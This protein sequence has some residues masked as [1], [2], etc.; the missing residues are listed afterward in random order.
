MRLCCKLLFIMTW[1]DSLLFV[2]RKKKNTFIDLFIRKFFYLWP[3]GGD[4]SKVIIIWVRLALVHS[5]LIFVVFILC[6]ASSNMRIYHII[7]MMMMVDD[8]FFLYRWKIPRKILKPIPL[9]VPVRMN[10]WL[11]FLSEWE[12]SKVYMQILFKSLSLPSSLSQTHHHP[13]APMCKLVLKCRNA[14]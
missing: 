8:P 4:C 9:K 5:S 6:E 1:Y 7:H 14:Q 13:L 10:E 11:I 12:M 3:H 2:W